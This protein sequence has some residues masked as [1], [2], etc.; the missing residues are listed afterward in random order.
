MLAERGTLAPREAAAIGAKLMDALD[1]AHRAGVLH[2]DVKPG[3]VLLERGDRVVLTDFGIATITT[4]HEM[5]KLTGSGELVGSLDYL[6]PERAQGQ[7]PTP[8]S[9]VWSL[10]MTLYAAVEGASPFR[11]TSVWSTLNSIVTEPLP[12]P[13]RSGPLAPVLR[14]LMTK[15]PRQRPTAERARAMLEAAA[16]GRPAP[17]GVPEPAPPPVPAPA[18]PPSAVSAHAVPAARPAGPDGSPDTPPRPGFGPVGPDPARGGYTPHGR[19][20]TLPL[21]ERAGSGG[22]VPTGR[23]RTRVVV[24][25]SAA[26]VLAGGGAAW[27]A[28]DAHHPAGAAEAVASSAG[29]STPVATPSMGA[30]HR[31]LAS[32]T[33]SPSSPAGASATASRPPAVHSATA[34]PTRPAGTVRPTP[35]PTPKPA[36]VSTGCTGWHH[37]DPDPGTTGYMNGDDHIESGP[38]ETCPDI[39]LARTGA[40]VWYQCY[41]VN[42]YGNRWTYIRI[43]GTESAG[44]MSNDNLENQDGPSTPC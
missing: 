4:D 15:D 42:A 36:E 21:P 40:K 19:G 7:E 13:A 41:V 6:P 33:T 34:A 35:H 18:P 37:D 5:A 29:A 26:V 39:A 16:V 38:Y 22:A 12:E 3:N 1:A 28:L 32:P 30:A 31:G 44:W 17:A 9:D 25:A 11:R 2:R 8:A 14:E 27:A 43:A 23:S 24:A 10:G 20:R